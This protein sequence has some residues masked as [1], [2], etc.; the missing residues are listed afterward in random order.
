MILT[1]YQKTKIRRILNLYAEYSSGHTICNKNDEEI[2]YDENY[3]FYEI[4][5]VINSSK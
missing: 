4:E 5:K 1:S 3:A 2:M